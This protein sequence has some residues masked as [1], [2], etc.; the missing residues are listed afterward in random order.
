MKYFANFVIFLCLQL[1]LFAA[2][3]EP[4]SVNVT[5]PDD[6]VDPLATL[7]SVHPR[8][9]ASAEQFDAIAKATDDPLLVE[10]K[11][12]VIASAEVVMKAPLVKYKLVGHTALLDSS[13]EAFEHI[14]TCSMAYR[15][16]HDVRFADRAKQEMLN[17]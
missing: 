6:S 5:F 17:V 8:L 3:A 13:R 12:R 9:I 15:L 4:K 14:V 10:V 2:D 1:G 16:T 11:K 7:K